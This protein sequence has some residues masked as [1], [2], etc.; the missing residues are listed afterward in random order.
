[1]LQG[2]YTRRK[3]LHILTGIWAFLCPWLSQEIAVAFFLF[4]TLVGPPVVALIIGPGAGR[5]QDSWKDKGFVTYPLGL[6]IASLLVPPAI[7][8]FLLITIAA[9]DGLAGFIGSRWGRLK[10]PHARGRTLE[11]T[12]AF[13]FAGIPATLLY[14]LYLNANGHVPPD[15]AA[16]LPSM[17][18]AGVIYA[19]IAEIIPAPIDDNLNVVTG[20][21]LPFLFVLYG[22]AAALI[23]ASIV[24]AAGVNGLGLIRPDGA[25]AG[26][27]ILSLL[28]LTAGLSGFLGY[29]AFAVLGT[30]ATM[31]RNKV[32]GKRAP[33]HASRGWQEA[34]IKGWIPLGCALIGRV[35]GDPAWYFAMTGAFAAAL[36]DTAAT[37]MGLA[38]KSRVFRLYPFGLAPTG[39]PGGVSFAGTLWGLV[40]ALVIGII[41]YLTGAVADWPG[42]LIIGGAGFVAQHMESI[43]ATFLTYHGPWSKFLTNSFVTLMGAIFALIGLSFL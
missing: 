6:A 35:T 17:F 25:L 40:G 22:D 1:M 24:I 27:V 39:S 19:A 18:V 2:S 4:L 37:E 41:G 21:L 30:L 42:V 16:N 31:R 14:Y 13:I 3:L 8:G 12:L 26:A 34:A 5:W 15:L 29:A 10:I 43:L 9:G 11:G 20:A 28:S 38:S 23:P 36:A 32:I 7:T 33:K